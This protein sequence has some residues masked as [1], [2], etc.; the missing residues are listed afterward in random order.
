MISFVKRFLK[1]FLKQFARVL[2]S[3]KRKEINLLMIQNVQNDNYFDAINC[4]EQTISIDNI[5]MIEIIVEIN[6]DFVQQNI[7]R[8]SKKNLKFRSKHL[9][10]LKDLKNSLK[11]LKNNRISLTS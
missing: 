3:K 9:R 2:K 5:K 10:F 6:S 7:K 8:S 4:V 1:N 11:C